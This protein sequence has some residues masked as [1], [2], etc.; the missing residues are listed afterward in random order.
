MPLP[1]TAAP[2]SSNEPWGLGAMDGAFEYV[3]CAG[4]AKVLLAG[5]GSTAGLIG[6][7]SGQAGR[8]NAER[9]NGSEFSV[10]ADGAWHVIKNSNANGPTA[11]VSG[12]VSNFD[13]SAWHALSF[14]L[15]GDTLTASIDG[16]QIAAITNSVY[17]S[18]IAGLESNW[19]NA[20]FTNVTAQ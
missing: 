12:T 18:G 11:L 7:V 13:S 9:F 1:Y 20:Q 16:Q 3:P 19:T 10:A 5:P 8:G 4:G 15:S 17:S 14:K 2:D 6:R